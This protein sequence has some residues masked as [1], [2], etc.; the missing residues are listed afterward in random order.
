MY[1]RNRMMNTNQNAALADAQPQPSASNSP[2]RARRL[3]VARPAGSAAFAMSSILASPASAG[4]VVSGGS[5]RRERAR[6]VRVDVAHERVTAGLERG[7]LVVLGG[8]AA[9]DVALEHRGATGV[10]HLDVVWDAGV[11]VVEV[12][13]ERLPGGCRD[14]G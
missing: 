10:L 8:D 9:E 4:R 5:A 13:R 3:G 6:H 7:D 12:D 1:P 11:L 14:V 2:N